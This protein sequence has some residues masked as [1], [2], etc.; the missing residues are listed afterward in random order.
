[1]AFEVRR[2]NA[3]LQVAWLSVTVVLSP[4]L[5]LDLQDTIMDVIK[6]DLRKKNLQCFLTCFFFTD[7]KFCWQ[8]SGM[9]VI[10]VDICMRNDLA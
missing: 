3:D 7:Y 10:H 9:N 5:A 6:V 2:T 8:G 1:M 4:F